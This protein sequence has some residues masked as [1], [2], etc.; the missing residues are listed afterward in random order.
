MPGMRGFFIP[1]L[2]GTC[3]AIAQEPAA[4]PANSSPWKMRYLFD[5]NDSVLTLTGLQFPSAKRGMACGIREKRKYNLLTGT[6]Q[7]QTAVI[8]VTSDAGKTWTTVEVKGL[9]NAGPNSIFFLDDST[10]WLVSDD[11]IW[12]TNESGRSWK[13][14]SSVKNLLQVYFLTT[15]RGF[16]VGADKQALATT[17]GGATWTPIPAS[18]EPDTTKDWTI[19]SNIAFTPDHKGGIISGFSRPPRHEKTPA[20]MNP[21]E[22]RHERQV[23]NVTIFLDSHDGG[24]TWSSQTASLFG[25]VTKASFGVGGVGLGLLEFRDEFPWPSEVYSLT[26]ANGVSDRAF[27]EKDRAITDVLCNPAGDSYIAGYESVGDV[28]PSPIP[29]K[30]KILRSADLKNWTEMTVDYRAAAR[31]VWLAA[32][33]GGSVWAATDT[34]MIMQLSKE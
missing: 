30:V 19:Y 4:A 10:G 12:F 16:A 18:S 23:P 32:A 34:G 11:G 15:R 25:E 8:L 33:P 17:D 2:V 29:G 5:E 1:L 22:G 9:E 3:V 7:T 13:R 27:R 20:W 6:R 21:D 24:Q 14:I 28:H 31:R 26:L